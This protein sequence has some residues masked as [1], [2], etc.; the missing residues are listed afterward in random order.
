MKK[1]VKS[2]K[3]TLVEI[4][5]RNLVNHVFHPRVGIWVTYVTYWSPIWKLFGRPKAGHKIEKISGRLPAILPFFSELSP[6][7][8]SFC[9]VVRGIYHFV[10]PLSI[11]LGSKW[12]KLTW[13]NCLRH[14]TIELKLIKL[15]VW[16]KKIKPGKP[17]AA[18]WSAV[19]ARF[20]WGFQEENRWRLKTSS[21]DPGYLTIKFLKNE[22]NHF[23]FVYSNKAHD[24]GF[25]ELSGAQKARFKL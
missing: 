9:L 16:F 1:K 8:F 7:I 12:I 14:Q 24:D 22:K 13:K 3:L 18:S 19:G 15:S 4:N 2:E 21:A 11:E 17:P 10:M 23:Y 6:W 5:L 25:R 20:F